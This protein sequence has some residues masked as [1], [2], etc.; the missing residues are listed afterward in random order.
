MPEDQAMTQR[1]FIM[2]GQLYAE[3]ELALSRA[4]IAEA[5]VLKL[6]ATIEGARAAVAPSPDP[7]STP[8]RPASGA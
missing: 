3:K 8:L 2:L 4:R 5:E 6:R 7:A 1:L